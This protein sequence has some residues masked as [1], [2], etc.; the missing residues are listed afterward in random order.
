MVSSVGPSMTPNFHQVS[1]QCEENYYQKGSG[2]EG[3]GGRP[4]VVE[5]SRLS[6]SDKYSLSNPY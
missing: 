4:W 5:G 1:V 2:G 3:V 6:T